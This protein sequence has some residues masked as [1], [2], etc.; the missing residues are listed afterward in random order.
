MNSRMVASSRV[1]ASLPKTS[2]PARPARVSAQDAASGVRFAG[3]DMGN[4]AGATTS[5][6][7]ARY[8]GRVGGLAFTLGVGAAILKWDG[9]GLRGHV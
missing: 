4:S 3:G 1:H 7:Y 6:G 9:G 5:T 2:S 8:V